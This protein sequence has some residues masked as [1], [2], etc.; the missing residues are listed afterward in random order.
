MSIHSRYQLVDGE[1]LA[2][3]WQ[4]LK[5]GSAQDVIEGL[6]GSGNEY[7]EAIKCLQKR[8]NKPRLLHQAHITAIVEVLGLKDGNV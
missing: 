7:E 5:D 6:L 3:L 1:K 8:Y 2:Y 4:S